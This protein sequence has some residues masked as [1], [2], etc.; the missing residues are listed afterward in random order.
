MLRITA[1]LIYLTGLVG[2]HS[3]RFVVPEGV[4]GLACYETR[5]TPKMRRTDKNWLQDIAVA[6]T[7][8]AHEKR[9]ATVQKLVAVPSLVFL[10]ATLFAELGIAVEPTP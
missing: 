10:A 5:N 8:L 9:A 1:T 6:N 3:I 2:A 7:A 4:A